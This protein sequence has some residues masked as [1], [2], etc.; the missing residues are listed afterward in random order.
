MF[1]TI[2]AA[3]LS[4]AIALPLT[5]APATAH[6]IGYAHRHDR[7]SNAGP[8]IAILGGLAALYLLKRQSD[9]RDDKRRAAPA[10]VRRDD[11]YRPPR[12]DSRRV[13]PD[14]CFRRLETRRGEVR[15]YGARCMQRSVARPGSLPP[16]CIRQVRTDRGTR[17]LYTARCMRRAGWT[18]R[19]ARR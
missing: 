18:S 6:D 14:N 15:G 3:T 11:I 5:T 8:A 2:L 17:N 1:R 19:T 13:L 10:P 9:R 16:E 7:G 4:A 12:R